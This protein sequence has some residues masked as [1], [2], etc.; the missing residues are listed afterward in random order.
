MKKN[1]VNEKYAEEI[2]RNKTIISIACL[3]LFIFIHSITFLVIYLNKNQ[4]QYIKYSENSLID[5]KVYLK[6]NDFFDTDYVT[7]ENQYIASLIEYINTNFKY[8]LYFKEEEID[9][10]YSYNI[11]AQINV[12]E[13]T[14]QKSLFNYKEILL[15]KKDLES[16]NNNQVLIS[17]KLDIDYNK[18]NNKIKK[19]IN[20][21]SLDDINSTLTI[22]M[23]IDVYGSCEEFEKDSNNQAVISLSIPLTTKTVGID[24][25]NNLINS[26]D[27]IMICKKEK[28]TIALLVLSIFFMISGII[29]LIW[30]IKY[31]EKTRSAES[32]YEKELKKILYN[33]HSYIQ[34]TNSTFNL[35]DYKLVEIKNFNDMI[36]IRDTENK[37]ILM[38]TNKEKNITYF[39]I[40]TNTNILYVYKLIKEEN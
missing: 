7:S 13:K 24:I 23:Y 27:N 18:Y 26:E 12:K 36:E 30:S 15:E 28:S 10:K 33:Y 37:P 14:Q 32:K 6:D 39:L 22:N 20:M 35:K 31:I 8:K 5:Y 38:T 19:F 34:E 9:F 29:L 1:Q 16:K 4:N 17:E 2:Q 11:E 21:Y 3:I 40:P 25:S